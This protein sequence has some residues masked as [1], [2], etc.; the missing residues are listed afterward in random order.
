[1]PRP[2]LHEGLELATGA[3]GAS[4]VKVAQRIHQN[5]V[6]FLVV[7]THTVGLTHNAIYHAGLQHG[8]VVLQ[9]QPI[10]DVQAIV[11][12]G[13][14]LTLGYAGDHQRGELLRMLPRAVVVGAVGGHHIY[15][16][17]TEVGSHQ[18][19]AAGLAGA[20]GAD[21]RI[22]HFPLGLVLLILGAVYLVRADVEGSVAL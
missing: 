13:D 11:V 19:V 3:L 15:A 8:A 9:Q 4:Q 10:T 5:Q 7:A 6:G 17:G 21:G 20:V 1:M 2:I 12:D 16:P 14:G 22:G 18:V